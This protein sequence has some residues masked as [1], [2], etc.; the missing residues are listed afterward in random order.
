MRRLICIIGRSDS[1]V[2]V[3]VF[4]PSA[5]GPVAAGAA[6]ALPPSPGAKPASWLD[7]TRQE[8]EGV[9]ASPAEEGATAMIISPQPDSRAGAAAHAGASSTMPPQ[10]EGD[11]EAGTASARGFAAGLPAA[12][13]AVGEMGVGAA[14]SHLAAASSLS[15]PGTR[16]PSEPGELPPASRADAGDGTPGAFG[17][18]TSQDP[19]PVLPP[20]AASTHGWDPLSGR[21]LTP[22]ASAPVHSAG[23]LS[24]PCSQGT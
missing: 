7:A 15:E 12:T 21:L 20:V 13:A 5:T 3:I 11:T 18:K 8:A 19:D 10:P 14:S 4:K 17:G 22:S 9:L 16:A 23:L 6:A 2:Q 1:A 24:H